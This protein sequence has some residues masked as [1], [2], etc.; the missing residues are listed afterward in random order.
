MQSP[1][2]VTNKRCEHCHGTLFLERDDN[3]W[4]YKCI[5]CGRPAKITT[6]LLR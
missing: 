1:T 4:L 3:K 6:Y 2:R 5:M